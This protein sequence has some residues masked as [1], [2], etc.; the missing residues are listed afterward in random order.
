MCFVFIWEQTATCATYSI[1]WLVFFN[2]DEKCL[3]RGTDW[4]FKQNG[5]P[6]VFKGL[7]SFSFLKA[8]TE[9]HG[10]TPKHNS[11]QTQF[12]ENLQ[13]FIICGWFIFSI[14]VQGAPWTFEGG[15]MKHFY[16]G[17][18]LFR[19]IVFYSLIVLRFITYWTGDKVLLRTGHEDSEG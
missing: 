1:N 17:W 6:F 16:R 8:S 18:Q 12:S 14:M 9:L 3:Q 5:L 2:R 4:G 10:F 19:I 15:G 7:K 13:C 11:Y